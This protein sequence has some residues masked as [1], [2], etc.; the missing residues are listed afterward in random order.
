MEKERVWF[1][2][3]REGWALGEVAGQTDE[4]T[5]KVKASDGQ[6]RPHPLQYL[7]K[8]NLFI[9]KSGS[10]RW[11]GG[12]GKSAG[13]SP[14]R[15]CPA[16]SLLPPLH[17]SNFT[18]S[19]TLNS[20]PLSYFQRQTLNS[21]PEKELACSFSSSLLVSACPHCFSF[22]PFPS[23][24]SAILSHPLSHITCFSSFSGL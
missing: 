8:Y 10:K 19:I 15:P 13:L 3:E 16:L 5:A 20:T 24:L 6:V 14:P 1:P 4:Q 2:S 11:E 12:F 21:L 22:S 23:H 17:F 9:F 18:F 7:S